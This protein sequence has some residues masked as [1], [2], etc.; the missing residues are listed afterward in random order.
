MSNTVNQTEN[1]SL[2]DKSIS[3]SFWMLGARAG[4]RIFQLIR[5]V[6]LARL[7]SPDDFGIMGILT[8]SL[9]ILDTFSKFGLDSA[10]IQ[11]KKKIHAYL[12]TFWTFTI[13][14][15]IVLFVI[16]FLASDWTAAFFEVPD[17]AWAFKI[18]AFSF[19]IQAL[20]NPGIVYFR[21]ELHFKKEFAYLLSGTIV[22]FAVAIIAAIIFQNFWALILG[23]LAGS[24]VRLIASYLLHPYRPKLSFNQKRFMELFGFGKWIFIMATLVFL[25]TSGDDLLVGKL[26]GVTMLGFYQ[27]AYKLSNLPATEITNV[28]SQVTFPAY[29][30]MQDAKKTL[31]KAYLKTMQLTSFLSV[32]L[33]VLLFVLAFDS[34]LF[35]LGEKWLPIVP[36]MQ[37]L[38]LFG[39]NR[40][41]AAGSGSVFLGT[42][43]P[44]ILTK[45]SLQQFILMA[46][47]IIP[48]TLWYGIIGTAI[49]MT[50]ISLLYLFVILYYTIKIL[51]ENW[52]KLWKAIEIPIIGGFFMLFFLLLLQPILQDFHLIIRLFVLTVLGKSLYIGLTMFLDSHWNNGK[53]YQNIQYISEKIPFIGGLLSKKIRSTQAFFK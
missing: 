48:A 25:I 16:F 22:D 2:F 34:V 21:K 24:I 46:I 13:G 27:M 39:L 6:I 3:G 31:Q 15:N 9:M 51:K 26:L 23:Y 17:A 45:L 19:I 28:I 8:L 42:N 30:K 1:T 53:L 11:T 40:S 50:G 41:L 37:I 52:K 44:K 5:L 47:F 7:L 43:N 10:L 4:D 35:F 32:P 14:R 49:V 12:D 20:T 33:S 18:I 38:V 36:A 29:S